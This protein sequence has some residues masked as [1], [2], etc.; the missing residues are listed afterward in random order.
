MLYTILLSFR[1]QM[2]LLN[3]VA[4][5]YR[6]FFNEHTWFLYL[7]LKVVSHSPMYVSLE[8]SRLMSWP[9]LGKS[10]FGRYNFCPWGKCLGSASYNYYHWN[11]IRLVALSHLVS[12]AAVE[13]DHNCINLKVVDFTLAKPLGGIYIVPTPTLVLITWLLLFQDLASLLDNMQTPFTEAQVKCLMLQ[14]LKGVQYLHERFVVHRDL[15]VSNLL[16]TGKGVLKLGKVYMNVT[17]IHWIHLCIYYY[18]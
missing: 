7:N 12:S 11:E 1:L 6:S 14:L 8:P 5:L 9:W 15:K 10:D 17:S 3:S 18:F 13:W 2:N 4:C 16:L